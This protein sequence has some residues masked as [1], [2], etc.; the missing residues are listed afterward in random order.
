[1]KTRLL[2]GLL[3]VTLCLGA[4][5]SPSIG[6]LLDKNGGNPYYSTI[7]DTQICHLVYRAPNAPDFYFVRPNGEVFVMVF[8]DPIPV[9]TADDI[10]NGGRYSQEKP[11]IRHLWYQD[12]K[13]GVHVHFVKAEFFK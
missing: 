3:S 10:A 1:M 12:G 4:L 6:R 11:D 7:K 13:D 5:F 8:S 2:V 9:F